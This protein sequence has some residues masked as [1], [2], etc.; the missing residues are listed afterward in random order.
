MAP[1]WIIAPALFLFGALTAPAGSLFFEDF[2]TATAD[3]S[4]LGGQGD[5]KQGSGSGG[6]TV[7]DADDANAGLLPQSYTNGTVGIRNG[8]RAAILTQG[9]RQA[10]NEALPD[11][12][13]SLFISFLVRHVATGP[14]SNFGAPLCLFPSNDAGTQIGLRGTENNSNTAVSAYASLNS[15]SRNAGEFIERPGL[16]LSQTHF[17]VA[18]LS[19]SG[20]NGTHYD[21]LDL[22]LNPDDATAPGFKLG[23]N[24]YVGKITFDSGSSSV[25]GIGLHGD[26]RSPHGGFDSI[27]IG[28]DWTDVVDAKIP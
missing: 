17:L 13:G 8:T 23:I 1:P 3:A 21:T 2:E 28:E 20:G 19:I 24:G 6:W 4:D 7:N 14:G 26:N 10:L 11:H 5:W 22:W 12:R 9:E 15:N 25:D 16:D 18:R 27:R